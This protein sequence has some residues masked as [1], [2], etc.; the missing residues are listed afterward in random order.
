MDNI[1]KIKNL[2]KSYHNGSQNISILKNI[3]LEI[4]KGEFV[5][6]VGTSGSGKT[7]LMNII[8]A[9]D[10]YDNGEYFLNDKLIKESDANELAKIRCHNFGFI[11]QRYNLISNLSALE[12][13]ALPSIYAGES[14]SYRMNRAKSLLDKLNLNDKYNNKPNE[15][16]GGQQQRVSIARALMNN[17]NIILA[18]EPTGALD[19]KTGIQVLNIL[20]QLNEEGHTIILITHDKS[21]AENA[22]RIIEIKDGEIV[23]DVTKK[24]NKTV[25]VIEDK[26][27]NFKLDMMTLLK[28]SLTMS[29][30]SIF[31]HKL[32]SFLT[33]LGIIIGIASVVSVVALGN[34]SQKKIMASINS[35][36]TNTIEIMAGKDFGDRSSEKINKMSLNDVEIL[37]SQSYVRSISEVLS[38]SF[39]ILYDNKELTANTYGV[40]ESYFDIKNFELK[41][42]DLIN[43]EDITKNNN[44]IIIDNNTENTLFKNENALGK[45]I[46]IDKK[47]FVVQGVL[48]KKES[49]FNQNENLSIYM[50]NTSYKARLI[51]TKKINRIIVRVHD[52]VDMSL[53]ESS[54]IKIMTNAHGEKD[55]FYYEYRFYSKDNA[56]K[57]TNNDYINFSYSFYI[58]ICWWYWCNEYY[59]SISYRK[60]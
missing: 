29:I 3:N 56:R 41:Y 18:D 54:I 57:H 40:N 38:G 12:N 34:G 28:E 47:P 46:L 15:L 39:T 52:N 17:G 48:K 55:F 1:I 4:K 45:V 23:S 43:K 36:G 8:G 13:V 22:N 19:S 42:G 27:H 5:A 53:A 14:F 58:I 25:K 59:V 44:I 33:M 20:K 24:E 6:I 9:I 31:S 49:G 51:N 32:R 16:S 7:T 35:M 2:N 60:N 26:K 21:I 30:Y 50:P 37:K 10:T 11:F